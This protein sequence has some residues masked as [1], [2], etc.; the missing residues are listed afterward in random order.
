MIDAHVIHFGMDIDA[1]EEIKNVSKDGNG[2]TGKDIAYQKWTVK[3]TKS[4]MVLAADVDKVSFWFKENV[5]S[6]DKAQ[7]SM[8]S[9]A[10]QESLL[11]IVEI[12][13]HSGT[14]INVHVFLDIGLWLMENVSNA[15]MD[16]NGMELAVN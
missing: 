9:D 6:V 7:F 2:T 12:L 4:M 1:K 8:D 11:T 15:L 10:L 5:K 13:S 14:V 3:I 16:M